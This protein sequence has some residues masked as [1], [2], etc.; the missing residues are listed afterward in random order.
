M[1]AFSRLLVS[2]C[3]VTDTPTLFTVYYIYLDSN[4]TSCRKETHLLDATSMVH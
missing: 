4:R 3:L 1:K 2:R